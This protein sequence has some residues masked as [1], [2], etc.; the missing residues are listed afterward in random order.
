MSTLLKS[1]IGSFAGKVLAT[2]FIGILVALGCGPEEW[3]QYILTDLPNYL[4]PKLVRYFLVIFGFITFSIVFANSIIS[5]SKN[6]FRSIVEHFDNIK[7]INDPHS[8]YTFGYVIS[9]PH[10]LALV[11]HIC[12][13]GVNKRKSSILIKTVYLRSLVTGE[14]IISKINNIEAN[15]LEILGKGNFTIMISMPN[16]DGYLANNTIRGL[17]FSNFLKRFSNF[18]IIIETSVENIN[19]YYDSKETKEWTALIENGLMAQQ[20]A[21]KATVLKMS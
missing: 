13:K 7:W 20:P 1:F 18:E 9:R 17:T 15:N 16:D 2:F 8:I 5:F 19:F 12:L 3:V 6:L 10:H 21:P 14:K 4:S 11:D